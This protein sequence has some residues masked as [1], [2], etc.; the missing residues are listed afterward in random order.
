MWRVPKVWQL[1]L[2]GG[3]IGGRLESQC[4]L[5]KHYGVS[6]SVKTCL[7]CEHRKGWVE[8]GIDIKVIQGTFSIQ[9]EI[10]VQVEEGPTRAAPA[11]M[12][13]GNRMYEKGCE[14]KLLEDYVSS[15]LLPLRH[16]G[17]GGSLG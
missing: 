4:P 16:T 14:R 3:R 17:F 5:C 11:R 15:F 9:L 1:R 13:P 8:Q 6:L 7:W 10:K 12:Q 2:S